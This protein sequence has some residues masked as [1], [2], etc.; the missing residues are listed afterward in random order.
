MTP[1]FSGLNLYGEKKK[2]S[3]A[4]NLFS[5]EFYCQQHQIP[6]KF[7]SKDYLIGGNH[8]IRKEKKNG[9]NQKYDNLICIQ[10]FE[11]I[12]AD[13]SFLKN[14]TYVLWVWEYQSLPDIFMR[15][16]TH[17]DHIF[18]VSQFCLKI[19]EKH[20]QTSVSIL[21]IQ[22]PIL[23]YLP[24]IPKHEIESSSVS[25]I[26][27]KTSETTVFGYCFDFNSSLVR[28][29]PLNLVTS[30]NTV[31]LN[32]DKY[33]LI[34]KFRRPKYKLKFELEAYN[35]F[36]NLISNNKSIYPI[37]EELSHLDLYKLYTHLDY[38]ISPHSCEGFGLTIFDNL[39]LGNKIISNFYSGEKDFLVPGEFIE[40]K[41]T[42]REFHEL[43]HSP[44]YKYLPDFMSSYISEEEI[45]KCFQKIKSN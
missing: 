1:K 33:S 24:L 23:K 26:I 25:E 15:L 10:P 28:K 13:F 8:Y 7:I 30:F 6:Y 31:F 29:N 14:K 41:H 44:T 34:L 2:C 17:F 12:E 42:L 16:E 38:Y 19:F 5:V 21:P 11:L 3:I 20:L 22:S 4:D 27:Q 40:L 39:K 45:I 32:S 37:D 43:Q 18:T 36:H 9:P 35:S